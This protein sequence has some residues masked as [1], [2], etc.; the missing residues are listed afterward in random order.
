MSN[1]TLT[2]QE[3]KEQLEQY[4][5]PVLSSRRTAFEPAQALADLTREQ[6]E[7]VLHWVSVIVKTNSA[8]A[9]CWW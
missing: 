6:Q 3:L 2:V 4:L 1:V 5:N 9:P 8:P 7:F